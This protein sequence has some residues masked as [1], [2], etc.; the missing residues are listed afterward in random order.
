MSKEDFER[1]LK[2]LLVYKATIAT[3]DS[4][5]MSVVLIVIAIIT[6]LIF[7]LLYRIIYKFI[8]TV[9]YKDNNFGKVIYIINNILISVLLIAILIFLFKII[10][11]ILT[12][13][14]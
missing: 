5:K 8:R 2:S 14:K 9:K 6:I 12:L 10:I 11:E 7:F 13:S 1:V 3:M 4:M